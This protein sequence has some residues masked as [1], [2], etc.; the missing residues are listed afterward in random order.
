[1]GFARNVYFTIKDGKVDEFNHLF[2][3]EVVPLLKTE[4]GLLNDT[5]MLHDRKGVGFTL[6]NDKTAADA[7]QAKTYPEVVK[8]LTPVL[9]GLPKV[10]SYD[11]VLTPIKN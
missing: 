3:N 8:K 9:E 10:E 4:K 1:M 11:R 7:Y 6:W 2:T 5:V